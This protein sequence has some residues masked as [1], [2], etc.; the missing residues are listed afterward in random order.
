MRTLRTIALGL[1]FSTCGGPL[2]AQDAIP[3]APPPDAQPYNVDPNSAR[4]IGDG[5]FGRQATWANPAL[6]ETRAKITAVAEERKLSGEA[7]KQLEA[8]WPTG[9]TSLD[10]ATTLDRF[11]KSVIL[12]EPATADLIKLASQ[13]RGELLLPEFPILRDDKQPEFLRNNLKLYYGRWLSQERYYEE[14]FDVLRGI[15]PAMVV[16]PVRCCFFK[17][18]TTTPY[19]SK[20]KASKR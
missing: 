20:R 12:L 4:I 1:A 13:H 7:L 5:E 19:S 18:S 15:E 16:D 9:E 6:A 14:S 11:G 3:I 10:P 8:L 17:A 2:V